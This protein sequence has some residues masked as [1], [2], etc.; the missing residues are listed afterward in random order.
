[1]KSSVIATVASIALLFL[2]LCVAPTNAQ[3]AGSVTGNLTDPDGAAM[4][5]L[6]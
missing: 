3:Q 4:Q 1:M 2:I 6:G 5:A